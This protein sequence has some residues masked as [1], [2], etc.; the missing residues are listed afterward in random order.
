MDSDAERPHSVQSISLTVPKM[1]K[2]KWGKPKP[3]ESLKVIIKQFSFYFRN[4][5]STVFDDVKL[6]CNSS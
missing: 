6:V 1:K 4:K 5:I 3:G 2:K